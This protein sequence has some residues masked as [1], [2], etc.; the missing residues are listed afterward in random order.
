M[1]ASVQTALFQVLIRSTTYFGSVPEY[2]RTLNFTDDT[3][4]HRGRNDVGEFQVLVRGLGSTDP[5]GG[6][7]VEGSAGL[8][9]DAVA[10][11]VEFGLGMNGQVGA[12]GQPVAQQPVFVLVGSALPGRVSI[13]EVDVEVPLVGQEP[14][15]GH[16]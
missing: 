5:V 2:G 11:V 1:S 10:D 13:R 9:V 15:V 4:G 8:G 7:P 6:G 3:L 14:P 16:L 12:F